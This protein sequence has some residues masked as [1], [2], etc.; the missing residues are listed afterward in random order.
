MKGRNLLL[1]MITVIGLSVSIASQELL[2]PAATAAS[3]VTSEALTLDRAISVA[4][5][6]NRSTKIA[7][8][9]TEKASDR[10]A[11]Q[12]TYRLPQFKLTTLVQ[13]PLTRRLKK[14]SLVPSQVKTQ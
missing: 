4:L 1:A 13:Q 7:R 11:E 8:L 10:V 12:K 14:A 5:E 6:N 3:P 9:E 2:T